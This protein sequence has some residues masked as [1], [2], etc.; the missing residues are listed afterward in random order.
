MHWLNYVVAVCILFLYLTAH[1]V[2]LET[3]IVAFPGHAHLR[4]AG[5][6]TPCTITINLLIFKHT[7]RPGAIGLLFTINTL[8]YML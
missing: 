1:R 5:N 3:V 8:S 7:L 6:L 2:G 4:F